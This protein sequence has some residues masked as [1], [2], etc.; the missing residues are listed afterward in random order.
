MQVIR[1]LVRVKPIHVKYFYVN[2][3][4]QTIL[5]SIGCC[6]MKNIVVFDS[7]FYFLRACNKY[8]VTAY[9]KLL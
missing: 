6:E 7:A 8:C 3:C 1:F 4:K 5:K 9:R 2:H